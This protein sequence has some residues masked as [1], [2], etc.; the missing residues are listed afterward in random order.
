MGVVY[1]RVQAW[2]WLLLIASQ[3]VSAKEVV[4]SATHAVEIIVQQIPAKGQ[5]LV[6]MIPSRQGFDAGYEQLS[7]RLTTEGVEVWLPDLFESYVRAPSE[8]A[9]N[10]VPPDDV[11]LVL[12]QAAQSGKH[13]HLMAFGRGAPLALNSW[14]AWQTLQ[15]AQ[16]LRGGVLLVS[17]NLVTKT[18]D[19]GQAV[20]YLSSVEAMNAPVWIFQPQRSPYFA[21]IQ[22]LVAKLSV[23]G[24]SVWL[25]AL[26]DM[27][28]RFF[29]RADA[30]AQEQ[31][32]AFDFAAK[33]GQAMTL[34]AQDKQQRLVAP[35]NSVTATQKQQANTGKL[36]SIQQA[37]PPLTLPDMQGQQ[38][39]LSALK[40]QVVL[41][42]FW[43]SWCPPCV[44][45]MPSMQ[46]L[47]DAKASQGLALVAVNLGEDAASIAAF[48]AQ[49]QLRFPI[50][51]DEDQQTAKAWK[52]FAYPTSF[53]IDRK[54]QVRFALAGGA[55]WTAASLVEQVDMLLTAPA[56]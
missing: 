27:R 30:N 35:M 18:P 1:R 9:L 14:R 36:L 32:Y 22:T 25:E 45:E 48:S 28:D 54:G 7:Q 26:P 11:A 13:V 37:A 53:L 46:R 43:A 41:L 5:H 55:D 33:I 17:P 6:V 31:V 16:V 49:H 19:P 44:H 42:N 56:E 21:D 47:I 38:Q 39:S 29:Y 3:G 8:S 4:V 34:M 10:A 23:G 40:G 52:V 20:E 51:R 50:W 24:A 2:V 12:S 15:P